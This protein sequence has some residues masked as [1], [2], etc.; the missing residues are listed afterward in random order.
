MSSEYFN[1]EEA[2][3][4]QATVMLLSGQPRNPV[5]VLFFHNRSFGDDTDLFE[6]AGEMF[7]AGRVRLIAVTNNEGERFGSTTP[8]EANPGM[9]YYIRHLTEEQQIPSEYILHP[10]TKAFNVREENDAFLELS[11]Q[12]RWRSGIILSQPHQLL[13]AMLGMVQA[14]D[15]R[16]YLMEIYTAAPISTPWLEEVHGS[17]GAERKPRIEHI[18]DELERVYLYQ[19]TGELAPFGQLF[20][21]LEAREKGRL[22]LG[23]L[24]RGSQRLAKDLPEDFH[25]ELL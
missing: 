11:S 18:L 14:M 23:P 10:S 16:G 22:V 21:Y 15:E 25:R 5:D 3:F 6:M 2:K 8:F 13:R 12:N 7:Q 9:T 17:Q 4:Y 1:E 19:D 20:E 24:E